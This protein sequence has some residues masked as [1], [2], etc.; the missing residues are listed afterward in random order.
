[1]SR[2]NFQ[3]M[4]QKDLH[5][6]VLEHRDDQEA[7]YV[8]IDKLHAEGNWIEMPAVESLE[9]LEKYPEFTARF[10]RSSDAKNNTA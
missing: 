4:S 2:T 5:R 6:Y 8:Y 1:M 10:Q 9:D 7:F 3:D